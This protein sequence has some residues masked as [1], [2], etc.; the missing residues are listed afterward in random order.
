MS[1]LKWLGL[2][3]L[4]ILFAAVVWLYVSPPDLIRV[5]SNYSAKI[6]CSNFFLA[7]RDPQEILRVDVQAPG[8]PILSLMQVEV[9]RDTK[10]VR[11]GLFGL[12]GHGLAIYRPGFGCTTVPD[13]DLDRLTPLPSCLDTRSSGRAESLARWEQNRVY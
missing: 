5:A 10:I 7:G 9:E 11:A 3:V 8:H 1:I 13:G 2:A 12:I 6:V 4:T